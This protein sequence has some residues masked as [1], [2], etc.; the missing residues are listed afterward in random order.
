MRIIDD[1]SQFEVFYHD[2]CFWNGSNSNEHIMDLLT[3][4]TDIDKLRA[5]ARIDLWNMVAPAES[6]YDKAST[7][8][9]EEVHLTFET[10]LDL[11]LTMFISPLIEQGVIDKD[12]KPTARTMAEH[13]KGLRQP[14]DL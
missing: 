11:E 10:A 13:V 6:N 8:G 5:I 3:D 7:L 4:E 1:V 9:I 2:G 14:T 12:G